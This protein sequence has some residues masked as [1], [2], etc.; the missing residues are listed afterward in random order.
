MKRSLIDRWTDTTLFRLALVFAALAVVPV[1]LMGVATTVIGSVVMLFGASAAEIDLEQAVFALL[2]LGGALGFV[3]Y[4]RAHRGVRKPDRHNVTATLICLAAGVVT[5]LAVAGYAVIGALDGLSGSW[6]SSA[7]VPL[8]TLF[9]AANVVWALSGI[10]WMQRLPRRY[11][12]RTGRSFDGL[13]A[14]LLFVAVA[15]AT[16]ATVGTTTQ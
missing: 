7:W 15:L 5:A 9:A 1:L 6:G 2:S 10:A 4:L 8:T 13:P 16:M 11:A 14:L 12:E 3:G